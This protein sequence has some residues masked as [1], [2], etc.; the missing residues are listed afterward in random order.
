MASVLS[1]ALPGTGIRAGS[2]IVRI[3]A[4]STL[5]PAAQASPSIPNR[6]FR[7]LQWHSSDP[8]KNG[9]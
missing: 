4:S 5:L 9:E 3:H 2:A 1:A 8:L 6:R 7:E